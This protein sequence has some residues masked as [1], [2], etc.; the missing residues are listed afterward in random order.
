MKRICVIKQ[1]AGLGDILFCLKIA[2]KILE[3]KKAEKVIWPVSDVYSY[4]GEYI[5]IPG[6]E[7][8][9]ENDNFDG[10]KLYIADKKSVS[11]D[12]DIM[13]INLQRAD[14]VIKG[15]GVMYCKYRMIDLDYD[16]W[17]SYLDIKRNYKREKKLE[18]VLNLTKNNSD[19]Y[20]VNRTFATYPNL[21]KAK[22]VPV[23]KEKFNTIEIADMGFDRIFDWL[24][25]IERSKSFHTVETAFCYL[26]ALC[27]KEEVV[28]YNRNCKTDFSYV[29]QIYPSNWQ[30]I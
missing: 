6:V 8:I 14:Q 22:S 17:Y 21:I 1:P 5:D 13:M 9:N 7:F 3:H 10:K 18:D 30:Y 23:F 2:V 29:K 28:V 11:Y 19:Y 26:A 4:L 27:N 20:L 16:D 24:G 12:D 15:V 25:I